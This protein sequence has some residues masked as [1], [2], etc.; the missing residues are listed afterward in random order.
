ANR[1]TDKCKQYIA[2][3]I[4]EAARQNKKNPAVSNP[5]NAIEKKE[6]SR[7]PLGVM[8][9]RDFADPITPPER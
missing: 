1:L 2:N 8:C 9:Y 7:T 5:R 6:K 4:N 3:L